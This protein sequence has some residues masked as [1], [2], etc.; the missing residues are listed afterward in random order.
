MHTLAVT[1]TMDQRWGWLSYRNDETVLVM[2]L[3]AMGA[4]VEPFEPGVTPASFRQRLE[5]AEAE[6]RRQQA[7]AAVAAAVIA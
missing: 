5:A 3:M 2:E 7:K 1:E 4:L 6:G